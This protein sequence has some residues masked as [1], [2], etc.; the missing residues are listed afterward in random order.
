MKTWPFPLPTG[1]IPWTP[2]QVKQ[3][4]RERREAMQEAPL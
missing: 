3:Y 2:A 4:A 1:P